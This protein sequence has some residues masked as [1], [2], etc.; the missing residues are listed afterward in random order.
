M[1]R[2]GTS[3]DIRVSVRLRC[4]PEQAYE[5]LTSERGL[6]LCGLSRAKTDA[7]SRGRFR[8][9]WPRNAVHGDLEASGVFVDLDPGNKAAWLFDEKRSFGK[10]GMPALVNIFIEPCGR[11]ARATLVHPGFPAGEDAGQ[12]AFRSLWTELLD[13][14]RSRFSGGRP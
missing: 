12:A 1:A 14:L 8:M 13:G 5:A 4:S 7:R 6:L 3:K 10:V 9:V 11:G 2:P